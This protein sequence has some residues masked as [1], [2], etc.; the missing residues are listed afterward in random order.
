MI[1]LYDLMLKAQN[2]GALDVMAKQF[3]L[4]QKQANDAI[5]ALMPAFSEA[6]KRS[7]ANPYDLGSFLKALYSGE[8]AKYF[9][10][11]TKAF[12]PKGI[13]E[14]NDL[15][16]QFFGSKEVSRAV[17]AQAAQMTGIGQEIYKQMLPVV[18]NTLMG[19]LFKQSFG[20][21]AG[22]QQTGTEN[23]FLAATQ[24]WL[25]ATGMAKKPEPQTNPFNNPFTQAFFGTGA[26]K[27]AA[28]NPFLDNPFAKSFSD[29]MTAMGGK[30]ADAPPKDKAETPADSL[31]KFV[32]TMFD[33][34]LEM[35]K[36]YQKSIEGIFDAMSKTSA[37]GKPK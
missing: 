17:A 22:T 33:T 4:A 31:T 29:M 6:L 20:P 1:P 8:Y 2:G 10:D 35:Q 14:G 30:P 11:V 25:E 32:S 12:T 28:E 15:L 26:D 27:S 36:D 19:G 21:F 9:D 13:E 37:A 7:A 23:P 5:T 18:A 34:G 16:G 3:G 24:Q